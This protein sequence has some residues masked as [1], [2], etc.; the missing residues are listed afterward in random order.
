MRK[1]DIANREDIARELIGSENWTVWFDS[2]VF[3]AGLMHIR[4]KISKS[5]ILCVKVHKGGFAAEAGVDD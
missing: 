2:G 1:H 4:D 5:E 3:Y